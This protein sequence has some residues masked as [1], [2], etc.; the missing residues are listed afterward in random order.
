MDIY[1]RSRIISLK[2]EKKVSN[3]EI[4]RVREKRENARTI[5]IKI[6]GKK[7]KEKC[8]EVKDDFSLVNKRHGVFLSNYPSRMTLD[9][10]L[11]SFKL[12]K[13]RPYTQ[14][15]GKEVITQESLWISFFRSLRREKLKRKL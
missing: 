7:F 13:T 4:I 5:Q 14:S 9:T 8:S 3:L 6:R 1:Y 2:T 10:Y 11:S 12:L 15:K